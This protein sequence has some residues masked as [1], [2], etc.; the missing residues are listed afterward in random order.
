MAGFS[1]YQVLNGSAPC[2]TR[3]SGL[4]GRTGPSPR[5]GGLGVAMLTTGN[6]VLMVFGGIAAR[7]RDRGPAHLRER[8]PR[9]ARPRN[10]WLRKHIGHMMGGYIAA[11]TAFLVQNASGL[12]PWWLTW[13]A[14]P[15]SGCRC[16]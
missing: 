11:S 4:S 7:E 8:A 10:T 14:P 16:W 9:P 6:V 13:L 5:W 15:S 3:R 2:G 12:G 1:L